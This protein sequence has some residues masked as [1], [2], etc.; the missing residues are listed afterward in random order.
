MRTKWHAWFNIHVL[1][2]RLPLPSP[3]KQ[4]WYTHASYSF[5]VHY[6][7]QHWFWVAGNRV[8]ITKCPKSFVQ[9]CCFWNYHSG[10]KGQN[11]LQNLLL[12]LI[13]GKI[14]LVLVLVVP[15]LQI[16]LMTSVKGGLQNW[17]KRGAQINL[18]ITRLNCFQGAPFCRLPW[19]DL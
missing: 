13:R 7:W 12:L 5:P 1:S 19:W 3:T 11:L 18:Q 16:T 14:N 15:V 9:D 8:F 2:T 4:C 17:K 6:L 10:K